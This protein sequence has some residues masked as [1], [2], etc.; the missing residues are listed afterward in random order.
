MMIMKTLTGLLVVLLVAIQFAAGDDAKDKPTPGE[1]S[2]P[3]TF[4]SIDE[5]KRWGESSAFGGGRVSEPY[6][7]G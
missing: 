1:A 4:A 5:L 3:R 6:K 2:P 7:L